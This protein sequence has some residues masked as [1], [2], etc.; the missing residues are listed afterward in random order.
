MDQE[1]Y[2]MIPIGKE[3]LDDSFRFIMKNTMCKR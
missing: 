1:T 3:T 2:D